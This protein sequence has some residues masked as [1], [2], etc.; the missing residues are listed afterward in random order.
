MKRL[1]IC[2]PVLLLLAASCATVRFEVPQPRDTGE[3]KA[4]PADLTGTYLNSDKDTL[5][6]TADGFRITDLKPKGVKIDMTLKANEAVLKQSRKFFVL[7]LNNEPGWEVFNFTYNKEKITV[8]YIDT[9][10]KNLEKTIR[11]LKEI[12]PVKEVKKKDGETEYFLLDP[13]KESFE[14]LISKGIFT[15]MAVFCR[16]KQNTVQ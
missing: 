15:K 10:K 16:V 2:L 3:L 4:F 12:T 5:V 11:D 6:I 7:S 1:M 13:S 8:Y 14:T 9:D